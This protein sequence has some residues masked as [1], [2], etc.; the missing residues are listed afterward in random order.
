MR[1]FEYES[2]EIVRRAGIPTTK[3]GFAKTS[4]SKG[5]QLYV[6]LNNDKAT[7][8]QTKTFSRAVAETVERGRPELV[9]SKMA[10]ELRPGKVFIDW[11]QNDSVKTTVS[12]YSLRARERPTVSTPVTWEEVA[13]CADSGDP[14]RLRFETHQVLERVEELGDLFAP[15]LSVTQVLPG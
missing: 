9:V 8:E 5:M 1:F 7:Y 10:K 15:V 14:E 4:G 11:S 3:F 2:R 12:V 6:P 13:D